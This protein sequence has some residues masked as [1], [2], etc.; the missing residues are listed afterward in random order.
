MTV[1]EWIE[2]AVQAHARATEHEAP[3]EPVQFD[4]VELIQ[5]IERVERHIAGMPAGVPH[6]APKAAP[7]IQ[8]RQSHQNAPSAK[9]R[10]AR[11]L[12]RL[13]PDE[14]ATARIMADAQAS[15]VELF[16]SAK[17]GAAASR[18]LTEAGEDLVRQLF[19]QLP[20]H[21]AVARLVGINKATVKR[22]VEAKE[23]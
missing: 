5:R 4:L 10:P 9:P 11:T 1:R 13:A 14:E 6:D 16:K 18:R 19:A 20:S 12:P 21:S 15:G 23:G 22:V 8:Q 17:S 2:E 7:A 3:P